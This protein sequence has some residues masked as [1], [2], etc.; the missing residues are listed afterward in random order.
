MR[1]IVIATILLNLHF[2][3]LAQNEPTLDIEPNPF[4]DTTSFI[5]TLSTS[6]TVSLVVYNLLGQLIDSLIKEQLKPQGTQTIMFVGDTLPVGQY[7]VFL[8]VDT[9]LVSKKIVK[10]EQLPLV[11]EYDKLEKPY[12]NIYPNPTTGRINLTNFPQNSD[13]RITIYNV[14]GELVYRQELNGSNVSLIDLSYLPMGM[15][16]FHIAQGQT[17]FREKIIKL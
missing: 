8:A 3:L 11:L 1:I 17:T 2:G 16:F 14:L 12:L 5:Y 4:V 15:Y 10:L 6:D 13:V 9:H 7:F